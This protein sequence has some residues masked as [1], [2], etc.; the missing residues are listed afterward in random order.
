[1][2]CGHCGNGVGG[3][4]VHRATIR[5]GGEPP[6]LVLWIQCPLCD[7]G[8]VMASTGVVYPSAP[9]GGE[10]PNLP[11]DVEHSWQ[12]ARVAHAVAAYTAA[13]MMCR[14]ILMHVAVDVAGSDPGKSFVQYVKDL[15]ANGYI[16]AGL[17]AVVDQIRDRGNIAN[18]ELPASTQQDSETTM[19]ITE[20]LLNGVYGLRGPTQP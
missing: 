12:E 19:R 10:V 8:S 5:T 3:D 16:T 20:H 1:M 18:H 2:T 11:A 17:R 7:D 4:V 6:S 13:E 9:A 14:K 15:D